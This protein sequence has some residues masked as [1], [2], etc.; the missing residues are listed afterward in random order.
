[1]EA[2]AMAL[3]GCTGL[4]VMQILAKKRQAVTRYDV[5]VDA[6]QQVG[7]PAVFLSIRLHHRVR[8]HAIS[9]EAVEHAIELSHT[10]YCSV[11]VMLEKAVAICH[12]FEVIDERPAARAADPKPAAAA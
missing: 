3:A 11:G 8:G 2:V 10:K 9:Q 1:M 7:P 12:T 6:E 4:D 5:Q